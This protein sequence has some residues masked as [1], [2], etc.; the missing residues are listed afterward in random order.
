M[1][2]YLLYLRVSFY[3]RMCTR[4]GDI[5]AY[6]LRFSHD[7][8]SYLPYPD[9]MYASTCSWTATFPHSNFTHQSWRSDI[10]RG[11]IRSFWQERVGG[12]SDNLGD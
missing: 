3:I 2:L 8:F 12:L 9:M 1:F 11:S 4:C 10:Q 5:L 6:I 7:C